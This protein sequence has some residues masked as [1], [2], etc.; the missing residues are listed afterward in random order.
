MDGEGYLQHRGL[1]LSPV[2]DEWSKSFAHV[3]ETIESC[4]IEQNAC[5][6][7]VID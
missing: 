6:M 7:N 5:F 3:K 4:V 2:Q 1:P